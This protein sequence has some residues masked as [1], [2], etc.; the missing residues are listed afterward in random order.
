M[1]QSATLAPD[2]STRPYSALALARE[3]CGPRCGPDAGSCHYPR[4]RASGPDKPFMTNAP[5]PEH[6]CEVNAGLVATT[7]FPAAAALKV[8]ML[9]NVPHPTSAMALARWW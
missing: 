1:R 6:L 8:R 3:Y 5:Q 9:R 4:T 7:C 2:G